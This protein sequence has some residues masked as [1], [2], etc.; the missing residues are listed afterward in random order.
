MLQYIQFTAGGCN[1]AL[2][3]GW[4]CLGIVIFEMYDYLR[5]MKK[6][7]LKV[8]YFVKINVFWVFSRLLIYVL[9]R[10]FQSSFLTL[11][12]EHLNLH[13]HDNWANPICRRRPWDMIE[14][15]DTA[16]KWSLRLDFLSARFSVFSLTFSKFTLASIRLIIIHFAWDYGNISL[17]SGI[18][19]SFKFQIPL[20]IQKPFS[21]PSL[22]I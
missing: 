1:F 6:H 11:K 4:S 22:W 13:S 10:E 15:P 17:Y 9:K 2:Y 16:T 7:S 3:Q 18:Q 5:C 21:H 8:M 14:R 20:N 19:D 12:T